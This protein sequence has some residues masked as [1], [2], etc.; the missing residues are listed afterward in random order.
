MN[1][2]Y[3]IL[4]NITNILSFISFGFLDFDN[5]LIDEAIRESQEVENL[6]NLAKEDFNVMGNNLQNYENLQDPLFNNQ[7]SFN[8]IYETIFKDIEACFCELNHNFKIKILSSSDFEELKNFMD[9]QFLD[10]FNFLN[11]QEMSN[12]EY[13]FDKSQDLTDTLVKDQ[14]LLLNEQ[15]KLIVT[16]NSKNLFFIHDLALAIL[17]SQNQPIRANTDSKE[18]IDFFSNNIFKLEKIIKNNLNLRE[19][20]F[21]DPSVDSSNSSY[22]QE[23]FQERNK[24][25]NIKDF[26]KM[27]NSNN[28]L[29]KNLTKALFDE[30]LGDDV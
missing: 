6:L 29:K 4:E 18:D 21:S 17:K 10:L 9:S 11:N 27:Y 16:E 19:V 14:A 2:A 25:D 7:Q 1:L 8:Y 23:S 15:E 22:S 13:I 24:L 12:I 28:F 20:D 3:L 5:N 26:F 30:N